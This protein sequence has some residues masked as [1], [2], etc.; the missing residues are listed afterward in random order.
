M[1]LNDFRNP[2]APSSLARMSY[3]MTVC[4]WPRRWFLWHGTCCAGICVHA[5]AVMTA[6]RKDEQRLSFF[7]LRG[8]G[9]CIVSQ[10]SR[11]PPIPFS[12][13]RAL[14]WGCT[15]SWFPIS[16]TYKPTISSLAYFQW[17]ERQFIANLQGQL[18]TAK[19]LVKQRCK[20]SFGYPKLVSQSYV[21]CLQGKFVT[22]LQD[23]AS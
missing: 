3:H 11:F 13:C 23:R 18:S 17:E 10:L 6:A 19:I 9:L 2:A 5:R 8:K 4:I 14:G 16:H 12:K 7:F 22:P 1:R 21:D 15:F 20:E